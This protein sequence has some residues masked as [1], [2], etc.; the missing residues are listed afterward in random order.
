MAFLFGSLFSVYLIVAQIR[1][2]RVPPAPEQIIAQELATL[3][4]KYRIGTSSYSLE[5]SAHTEYGYANCK[6]FALILK[7]QLA[8]LGYASRRVG[9]MSKSGDAHDLL[10]INLHGKWVLVDAMSN[11]IY[12]DSFLD[13][14]NNPQLASRATLPENFNEELR[15]LIEP[16]FFAA[17]STVDLGTE[18]ISDPYRWHQYEH[19]DPSV[20]NRDSALWCETTQCT[21]EIG[22]LAPFTYHTSQTNF[23]IL[24][25][26]VNGRYPSVK[27]DQ[28]EEFVK[29]SVGGIFLP[30]LFR[31]PD[32]R[33]RLTTTAGGPHGLSIW[34]LGKPLQD[35]S[36]LQMRVPVPSVMVF[37]RNSINFYAADLSE[38]QKVIW[39]KQAS[40]LDQEQFHSAFFLAVPPE[41][42][43]WVGPSF[44]KTRSIYYRSVMDL[45]SNEPR[46]RVQP[47]V[48]NPNLESSYKLHLTYTSQSEVDLHLY[49][50]IS[51]KLY[52]LSTLVPCRNDPCTEEVELSREVMLDLLI[53]TE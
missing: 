16:G 49:T 53:G 27:D 1:Q 39:S 8:N 36:R 41:K 42:S 38:N 25:V 18:Y 28:S 43:A 26:E 23:V 20:L 47:L 5:Y 46:I 22:P 15:R 31:L 34:R 50:E 30:R 13:I 44:D 6:E 4:Q 9:L 33:L 32:G 37:R 3:H 24:K 11:V 21:W 45:P 2:L 19:S 14:L 10:E 12:K 52:D 29:T 35:I 7:D 40:S 51:K 48:S 17:A